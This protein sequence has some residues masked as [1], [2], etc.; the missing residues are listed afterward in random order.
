MKNGHGNR[1]AQTRETLPTS[2]DADARPVM[3]SNNVPRPAL[4]A[5][6]A[7]NGNDGAAATAASGAHPASP[8]VHS[9]VFA[10]PNRNSREGGN[11]DSGSAS[12]SLFLHTPKGPTTTTSAFNAAD[13]PENR[14]PT[15]EASREGGGEEEKVIV[16]PGKPFA[17][18]KATATAAGEPVKRRH[19]YRTAEGAVENGGPYPGAGVA[20]NGSNNDAGGGGV[21]ATV[22]D[23]D[24]VDCSTTRTGDSGGGGGGSNDNN[25]RHHLRFSESFRN[26]SYVR[27]L[28]DHL[29]P[30]AHE[31]HQLDEDDLAYISDVTHTMA[32]RDLYSLLPYTGSNWFLPSIRECE[33]D[34]RHWE[35]R[36]TW[37][38]GL[39]I[40]IGGRRLSIR[41][42]NVF[43]RVCF[44]VLIWF[45]LW[46]MLPRWLV[47][48]GGYVWDP[49]V[50]VVVS[51]IVGGLVCRIIQMPPLVGVLWMGIMWNNIPH[52]KYL[53]HGIVKEVYDICS[54][55]GLTVI[56]ARAG[57][58]L[59]IKEILP[60]W[61]QTVLLATLPFAFEG[62]AHSLIA[63][64]IFDYNDNYNWAF[65][66]GMLCSIVSPA[67]VVPGSLYLQDLGYGRG[68]GPLSLMLSAV[69]IEIVIGVWC[70]NFII[71]LI[72]YD[73][74]LAVA[75][76]LGPVQF[77]G[78]IAIG[79]ALGVLFYY[80]VELIKQEADRLPNGK[81]TRDHLNSCMD[82]SYIIFLFAC[83]TMVF[84][85][86]KVSLA[87]GGCVMCVFFSATVAHMWARTGK[88]EHEDHK[89]YIASWLAFTWDQAM[90]P[91]LFAT[92]GAK[93]NVKAI[94]NGTFF[95]KAIIC[96]VCSTAV[97]IVV[98]FVIQLGSGMPYKEKLLVCVGYLG[99]ASAQASVGPIAANLVA[100]MI[101]AL[102][103]DQKHSLDKIAE[104]ANNV[105][106]ISA[107]YVM[108]M[109]CVASFG[110]VRGG[111]LVLT[112]EG[113]GKKKKRKGSS[114]TMSQ[115]ATARGAP[116][117][118]VDGLP[119]NEAA[120][121]VGTDGKA[122][123]GTVETNQLVRDGSFSGHSGRDNDHHVSFA[124]FEPLNHYDAA[125]TDSHRDRVH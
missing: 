16:V 87:G 74:K 84:L 111:Q 69:G 2:A 30:L 113:D 114:S 6:A 18:E 86:Y 92:M 61:K 112:R 51:A 83:Y 60:H 12:T 94:F 9:S 97:R 52:L 91:I 77:I 72:F 96:M 57:Y 93:I 125:D 23:D 34:E 70:A 41:L 42:L 123:R 103:D 35:M 118:T 17:S 116:A 71:G 36:Y 66:Q 76:V 13:F 99:K 119:A 68:V 44:M 102:P 5:P 64:K 45:M 59:A 78:G 4:A 80:V 79:V 10:S 40:A 56:L 124:S 101:A 82:F 109:A 95:P 75:I 50:L 19:A 105:Q 48:P 3:T 67:V 47:E 11:T 49:A 1:R 106:Q 88:A 73:Q 31:I 21:A 55:L 39:I 22:N 117:D 90:M 15:F 28:P 81:Y 33:D 104:Y 122:T 115:Q 98:I 85:G 89:K 65:L 37:K 29:I 27:E 14:H 62:V 63:N 8:G 100:N 46:N 26:Q 108:F 58:K 53:T 120:V 54:K 38:E 121:D 25:N 32:N 43:I 7:D 110:L 24:D 20:D 107:M